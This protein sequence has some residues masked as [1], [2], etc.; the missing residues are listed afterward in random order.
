M[1]A[2]SDGADFFCLLRGGCVV[3]CGTPAEAS[4]GADVFTR[5]DRRKD[6][7]ANDEFLVS[8][9]FRVGWPGRRKMFTR[10]YAR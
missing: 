2:F 4:G 6:M 8:R 1:A 3:S 7:V 10:L 5:A 9:V